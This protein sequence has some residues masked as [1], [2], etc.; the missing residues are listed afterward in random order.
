MGKLF[1]SKKAPVLITL[2]AGPIA[3]CTCG[4]STHLPFCDGTHH[5]TQFTAVSFKKPEKR[6][7]WLCT[8]SYTRKASMANLLHKEESNL[9]RFQK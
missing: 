4:K 1:I 7:E 3:W 6:E 9:F 2:E 8:N 5:G